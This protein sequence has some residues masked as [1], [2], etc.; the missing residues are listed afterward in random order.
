MNSIPTYARNWEGRRKREGNRVNLN[1]DAVYHIPDYGTKR[2]ELTGALNRNMG[3]GRGEKGR[4]TK[5][6]SQEKGGGKLNREGS[7]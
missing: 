5:R 7:P 1:G 4:P 3:G 2:G 6:S